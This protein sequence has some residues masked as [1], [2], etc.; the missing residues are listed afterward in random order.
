MHW[1]ARQVS[2]VARLSESLKWWR[3]VKIHELQLTN[4]SVEKPATL[5]TRAQN[6]GHHT[7]DLPEERGLPEEWQRSKVHL[8]RTRKPLLIRHLHCFKDT[9]GETS[10]RRGFS[11]YACHLE[12]NWTALNWQQVQV[13]QSV[14]G[15]SHKLQRQWL[16]GRRLFQG[17]GGQC[18]SRGSVT[19][20][21]NNESGTYVRDTAAAMNVVS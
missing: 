16:W 12:V 6:K 1:R 14:W 18:E 3:D 4:R 19:E 21:N 11:E 20:C 15:Q 5:Q 7:I 8:R 9:T 10:K 2:Q 17:N 13:P